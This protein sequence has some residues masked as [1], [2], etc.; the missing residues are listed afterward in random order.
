MTK[1]RKTIVK[2]SVYRVNTKEGK[3][4]RAVSSE[5]LKEV[6][7]NTKKM[8]EAGIKI[9][10]PYAHKDENGV[11]PGPL[12]EQ[13]GKE[14][15]AKTL[16]PKVWSSDI[17]AGFWDNF[18]LDEE[19]IA[20]VL[21]SPNDDIGETIKDTSIYVDP[22][23]TDGLGRTW[24]N[25][26][27]HVALVTNPVEPY[28]DNFTRISEDEHALAMSF[29]MA[30]EVGG[31][32]TEAPVSSG[33]DISAIVRLM[34]EKFG[35]AFP[36]NTSDSNFLDRLLTV[37]TSIPNEEEGEDGLT[38]KPKGSEVQSSPIIM[39]NENKNTQ[40]DVNVEKAELLEARANKLLTSYVD[41]LKQSFTARINALIKK[42]KIGKDYAEKTLFP[43]V[44]G[45]SMSLEDIDGEGNF[46]QT[47][48]EM[49]LEMLD[50]TEG[51]LEDKKVEGD[52]DPELG[53]LAKVPEDFDSDSKESMSEKEADAVYDRI[54]NNTR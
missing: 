3:Q 43:A 19:S 31:Q 13:D 54:L 41:Q 15:D 12:L 52:L 36:G 30:D 29:S 39:A 14:V 46:S 23:F 49:S 45:L 16:E 18:E 2:P 10:A 6:C 9:P 48:L 53:D 37:L 20:G 44:E 21:E 26:I 1:F 24:K 35:I 42:G 4:I 27:R 50:S 5:F 11:Y 8:M 17:N 51:L 47:P 25:V 34:E 38:G 28:Q 7:G 33:G 40:E 32:T 22:E